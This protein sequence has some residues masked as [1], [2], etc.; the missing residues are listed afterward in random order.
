MQFLLVLATRMAK[1]VSGSPHQGRHYKLSYDNIKSLLM[2]NL[3]VL[4][5]LTF[6]SSASMSY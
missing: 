5:I 2:K 1:D 6:R 3:N 4:R